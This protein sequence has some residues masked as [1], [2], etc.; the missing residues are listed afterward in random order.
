MLIWRAH[1][2]LH[3]R[4]DNHS[5]IGAAHMSRAKAGA[6]LDRGALLADAPASLAHGSQRRRVLA[7]D[8]A[9]TVQ[10]TSTR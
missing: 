8:T 2:V 7:V 9:D 6:G 4:H 1:V 3:P 10:V 5:T